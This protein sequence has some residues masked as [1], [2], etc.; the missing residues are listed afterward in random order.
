MN[1]N[2]LFEKMKEF[3]KVDLHRHLEGSISPETLIKIAKKYGGT[4]PSH[5]LDKLKPLIQVN[6]DP[7]GFSNFLSK[8][9]VF[10]GF[11]SIGDAIAEVAFTAVK[12]AAEDNVKY[13]ELRYS[14]THFA[15][16]GKFQESD[17]I[18]LIQ[19]SIERA[20][21][22]FDI[23]VTP[24]LT[25]SRD[26]DVML[27]RNT[28]ELVNDMPEGFFYGLDIAGDEVNNSAKPFAELFHKAKKSG[29]G[30]TIHA[31]EACGPANVREAV[32]DFQADRIGHGIRSVEDESVMELLCVK[33]VMLEV[34]LTSNY[35]TGCVPSIK[36][37]PIRK[38][39]EMGVQVS[40]NT[41]DP[42]ILASTLTN[43]YITAVQE[44]GFNEDDF[45]VLNRAA[46]EHSFYP[47]KEKLK[48]LLLHY[49]N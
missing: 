27:A 10:R 7:P 18:K 48:S 29:M 47:D 22:K 34:C 14:P 30:L 1:I 17:V 3:P 9:N 21:M 5:D 12:E 33:N 28:V 25:I 11:Y 40:L 42:A 26:Y 41:D 39:M 6:N 31:G 38:F 13:L 24:I 19:T 36:S 45:K 46:I 23:I 16:N 44:L 32:I 35:Y 4:L 2:K 8:F 20:S 49:W 15:S 37:H 43:E